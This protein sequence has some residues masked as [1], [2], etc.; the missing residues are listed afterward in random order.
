MYLTAAAV[1]Q[2]LADITRHVRHFTVSFD[3]VTEEVVAESGDPEGT[4]RFVSM[5]APWHY[6]IS[7]VRSLADKAAATILENVK[8]ADLHRA[9][10]PTH[11]LANL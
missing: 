9:Y 3:Y 1:N 7:D 8:V 10:W 5:G 2:V 4:D 6:G 11:R